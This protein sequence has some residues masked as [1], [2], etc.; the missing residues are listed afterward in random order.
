MLCLEGLPFQSVSGH[1]L[2]C[3]LV[4]KGKFP[5]IAL[6]QVISPFQKSRGEVS[7]R[8]SRFNSERVGLSSA[9][10]SASHL[11][12]KVGYCLGYMIAACRNQGFLFYIIG[13]S[14]FFLSFFHTSFL[15]MKNIPR[16]LWQT[17]FCSFVCINWSPRPISKQ[18]LVRRMELPLDQNQ[19]E[20]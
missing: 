14:C 1:K 3:F 10:P 6:R 7:F 12:S 18:F 2:R 19:A 13:L 9:L 17:P 15:R 5:Q 16:S 11:H 8:L 4:I 20:P